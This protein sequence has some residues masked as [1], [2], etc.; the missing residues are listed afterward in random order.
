[1]L[2]ID[3]MSPKRTTQRT[4]CLMVALMILL[5]SCAARVGIR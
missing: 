2:N 4:L 5:A 1:M 3:A